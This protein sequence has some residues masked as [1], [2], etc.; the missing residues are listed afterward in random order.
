MEKNKPKLIERI[1]DGELFKRNKDGTY[2]MMKSM[3][4]NPFKYTYETLIEEK[5]K[6]HFR[7]I[8]RVEGMIVGIQDKFNLNK[9]LKN[10]K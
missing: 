10:I 6:G 1:D 4:E 8:P 3:M 2:S 5:Y 9:A 7:V